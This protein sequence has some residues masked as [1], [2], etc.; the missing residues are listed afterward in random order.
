MESLTGDNCP[1]APRQ[2]ET[3]GRKKRGRP[4]KNAGFEWEP[5]AQQSLFKTSNSLTTRLPSS[6]PKMQRRKRASMSNYHAPNHRHNLSADLIERAQRVVSLP[7]YQQTSFMPTYP[8]DAHLRGGVLGLPV[9]LQAATLAAVTV[10]QK[11]NNLAMEKSM[12]MLWTLD[13][14][15]SANASMLNVLTTLQEELRMVGGRSSGYM[16]ILTEGR[17]MI[18]ARLWSA[19]R[20]YLQ[21]FQGVVNNETPVTEPQH[22]YMKTFQNNMP[23][24]MCSGIGWSGSQNFARRNYPTGSETIDLTC[25]S[26]EMFKKCSRSRS[27]AA[28]F[29]A[30]LTDVHGA[31]KS[32]CKLFESAKTP[33]ANM[34][35]CRPRKRKYQMTVS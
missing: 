12:D 18:A 25:T 30:R 29:D 24:L 4:P 32:D 27:S 2:K 5:L 3:H 13:Y 7:S 9:S 10:A 28:P 17:R 22:S 19:Q 6:V 34:Q 16:P 33:R 14:L 15:L 20:Y 31:Y 21:T 23:E 26:D 35:S 1:N 8:G 11:R